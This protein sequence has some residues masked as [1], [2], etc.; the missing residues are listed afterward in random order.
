MNGVKFYYEMQGAGKP[1]LLL[2][3]GGPNVG[4]F[5]PSLSLLAK[6]RQAILVHLQGHGHTKDIDRPFRYETM[7]DDI[8]ALV[9]KLNLQ[10][11]D[12]LGYSL[13]GGVAL[14]MAIRHPQ[15]VDRLILAST[16]MK[17]DGSY[18][19]VLAAF[20]QMEANA[21]MI[22]ANIKKSPL[23]TMYPEVDW[24]TQFRKMGDMNKRPFDW[25]AGVATIKAKTMLV[26]AD[27]DSVRPEHMVEFWKALG[28]GQHDAGLD[29][30]Q[31]PG[32]RL[33]IIPNATHYDLFATTAVAEAVIPFLEH[34][35]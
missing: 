12:I 21:P 26:F 8:A 18:P 5:G 32:A 3:G 15:V 28:G 11:V 17:Y 16:T 19:E 14:Q 7:A 31:R 29:G 9:T 10:K 27:A 13:G 6:G 33:A 22:A 23:A 1:L 20:G 34:G 2:H 24:E 35:T 25:S 30:S 4:V